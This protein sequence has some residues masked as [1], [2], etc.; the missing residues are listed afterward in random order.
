[1]FCKIQRLIY[2]PIFEVVIVNLPFIGFITGTFSLSYFLG[3]VPLLSNLLV[4]QYLFKVGVPLEHLMVVVYSLCI[5]NSLMLTS[6]VNRVG[7]QS[8][9]LNKV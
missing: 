6:T 8:R 5:V 1:M 3:L 4:V 2:H 9:I 7:D